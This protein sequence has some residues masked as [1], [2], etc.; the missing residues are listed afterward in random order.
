MNDVAAVVR[1]QPPLPAACIAPPPPDNVQSR[2]WQVYRVGWPA[3]LG[4]ETLK[5]TRNERHNDPVVELD[6][7]PREVYQLDGEGVAQGADSLRSRSPISPLSHVPNSLQPRK[8]F[9]SIQGTLNGMVTASSGQQL[10]PSCVEVTAGKG[11]TVILA[12]ND[13]VGFDCPI[14][15][16]PDGKD[17]CSWPPRRDLSGF[18]SLARV[19][20]V[21]SV[22][23]KKKF[24][25]H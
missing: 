1:Y 14:R 15:A 5:S 21:N 6:A 16:G 12:S 23:C 11:S 3:E 20:F 9:G 22:R 17:L 2:Q 24:S 18:P 8:A 25:L 4:N 19:R 10:P 7:S 13:T